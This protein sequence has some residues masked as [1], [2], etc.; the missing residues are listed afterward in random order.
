MAIQSLRTFD[1][2]FYTMT[3]PLD[4]SDYLFEF[5]YAQRENAWYFS[6]SLTDGTLLV[7][8]V[9]VV[10]SRPLLRRYADLRLPPG[11]LMAFPNTSD[12]STPGMGEL[13][14]DRRVAL[15]YA[16]ADEGL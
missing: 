9:K 2:P 8:G 14:E 5:R 1:D 15:I 11:V 4:G 12:D 16:T 10:C 13:G 7:A 3:T 6:I